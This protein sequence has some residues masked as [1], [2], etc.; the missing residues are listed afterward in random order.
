M[1]AG[2]DSSA[3]ALDEVRVARIV[4]AHVAEPGRRDLGVLVRPVGPVEALARVVS[5]AVP[6]SLRDATAARLST[7]MPPS[8]TAALDPT[9]LAVR[10]VA[11]AAR[12]GARIV[13]PEDDEWSPRLDDLVVLSRPVPDPVERDTDPP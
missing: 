11:D 9:A 4:L 8:G 5:G 7:V 6:S 12:V 1:T 10:V 13:T 3:R 2:V